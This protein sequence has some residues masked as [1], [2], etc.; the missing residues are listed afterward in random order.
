[1]DGGVRLTRRNR[2]EDKIYEVHVH[3]ELE[4]KSKM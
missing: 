3:V 2:D 4:K 1:M